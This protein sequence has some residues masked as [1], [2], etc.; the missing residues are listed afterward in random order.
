[1]WQSVRNK[2]QLRGKPR[3]CQGL[4]CGE[5]PTQRI[6]APLLAP[7]VCLL[8]L[9]GIKKRVD[10]GKGDQGEKE[11][12]ENLRISKRQSTKLAEHT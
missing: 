7:E 8:P 3:Q 4:K 9:L 1:M 12:S 6:T 5:Q 11:A 2:D 10:L